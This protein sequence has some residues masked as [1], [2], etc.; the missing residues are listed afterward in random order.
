MK[1]GQRRW[2]GLGLG[3]A[4]ALL[5]SFRLPL[6]PPSL[7][8]EIVA[9]VP[10]LRGV[11]LTNIDSDVLF[12]RQ[13]VQQAVQRLQQLHFNTLY[14]TVW[15]WGYTLY[16]S[17]VAE[18]ETGRS[19][20]PHPGLQDRDMLAELVDQGH[21]AGLD[22]IPW[23]EFG[24][25]APADSELVARHPN[26]V[27][28]RYDGSQI[29]MEGEH[30]R[31]WLNPALPEVRQFLVD[32][33]TELVS[34][35]DIDGIQF[36]DHLGL[37]VELGYDDYSVV[38]YRKD[39]N[40]EDPPRNIHDSEWV[41]WR[42]AHITTLMEE[43]F[44]AVK[45]VRSNCLVALAPN[46][47]EFAY[48]MYLQDW[49]TWERRGWVEELIVQV[50]RDNMERFEYE[51]SQPEIEQVR[52]HIPLGVGILTGLRNR[53][54]EM[55]LITEQVQAVRDRQLAG[56][57]FFFYETLGD[58]DEAFLNL[59]SEP[60]PRPSLFTHWEPEALEQER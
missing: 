21:D 31:V 48:E 22:V 55:D 33:V 49:W 24:L 38:R 52:S 4:I 9:D 46:P 40:G 41:R 16:P 1:R 17:A 45:A 59:F 35:Y 2:I 58:R 44:E 47:R 29:V 27:T 11:W 51:L 28:Q 30:P 10:E 8:A 18:R 34:T 50:Y 6:V 54:V 36:D 60:A 13:N 56:V 12:S 7:S 37:P 23:V 5:V 3:L 15:N 25:M 53:P 57:S 32:L 43:I 20:D 19:L 14:P 42:A 39:H 26:W